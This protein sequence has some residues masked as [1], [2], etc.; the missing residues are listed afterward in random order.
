MREPSLGSGD[1]PS[2]PWIEQPERGVGLTMRVIVW[3]ALT[4]GRCAARLVLYPICLY[5]LVFSVTART[6]S[7]AYLRRALGR[8]ARVSDLFRHYYSFASTILDRVF[9]LKSRY[10]AFDINVVGEDLVR[11]I[12]STGE[13]C[14]LIGAHVGSFEVLRALARRDGDVPV[15][16]VMYEENARK[17]NQVLSA[18]NPRALA[19]VIPLGTVDSMLKVQNALARGEFVGM[20]ADRGI[21]GEGTL[22]C[23]FLGDVARFPL[24]PF[25]LAAMLKR[26]IILMIGLYRGGNRYDIHFEQLP[27]LRHVERA[28][29]DEALEHAIKVYAARL[30]HYCRTAPYNWFNFY[31]FWA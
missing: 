18:I 25:R 9:F 29:R 28:Q 10:D 21:D 20:L 13:G 4:V 24:G 14:L 22:A 17:L 5:F 23:R 8:K 7:G 11:H 1:A 6:A 3:I 15:S 16:M 19:D 12:T 31:D 30:E 27:D 2:Q 26:P